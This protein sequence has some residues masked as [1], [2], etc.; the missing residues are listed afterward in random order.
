HAAVALAGSVAMEELLRKL[1]WGYLQAMGLFRDRAPIPVDP[2][3]GLPRLQTGLLPLYGCWFAGSLSIL[4][5][6]L[7]RD[8]EYSSVVDPTPVD[9]DACWRAWDEHRAAW[10]R[11]NGNQVLLV[12][13]EACLRALPEVLTGKRLATDVLFPDASMH[14]VEGVY[15]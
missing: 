8:G 4:K 5:G 9:L 11:D 10:S 12:L 14:L 15:K 6:C 7:H 13:V 3:T 1:L 2:V